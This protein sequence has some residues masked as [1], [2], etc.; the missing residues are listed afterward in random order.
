[1]NV[2]IVNRIDDQMFM[3]NYIYLMVA[4]TLEILSYL[5]VLTIVLTLNLPYSFPWSISDGLSHSDPL[6]LYYTFVI[7][8][9]T[10][11]RN[12]YEFWINIHDRNGSTICRFV[13]IWFRIVFTNLLMLFLLFIGVV[14]NITNSHL[15]NTLAISAVIFH[16]LLEIISITIRLSVNFS[17]VNKPV[18]I[19]LIVTELSIVFAA[20]MFA[21]C[22]INV[23]DTCPQNSSVGFISEYL[24]FLCI[25]LTP[26][27]RLMD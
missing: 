22:F 9:F 3:H 17:D 12:G 13:M 4:T 7:Y 2:Q 20:I 6:S 19:T 1:M 15:H 8:L 27:F 18:Y 21:L 24:L 16:F 26:I 10:L 14:K 23:L 5:S 25:V 11:E